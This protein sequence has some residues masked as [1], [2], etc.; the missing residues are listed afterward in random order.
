M[1][2][3][4]DLDGTLLD[5]PMG[6][7]HVVNMT[8]EQLG[9]AAPSDTTIRAMIGKPLQEMF[10]SFGWPA[11]TSE[12]SLTIFRSLFSE[13]VVS[14][15][16][17]LVF[18]GMRRSLEALMSEHR[19]AVATSKVLQSAEEILTAAGLREYFEVVLG[20]DSVPK[21]K[22]APDM[23]LLV[24]SCLGVSPD[25]CTVIGDSVH[26]MKMAISGG[27]TG[28]GVTWGVDTRHALSVAGASLIW[29]EPT[30]IPSSLLS[31]PLQH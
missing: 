24:A 19:L 13:H 20:A 6:I 9:L 2:I 25:S 7:V 31:Q 5:T 16:P 18:P 12:Q 8:A 22:P 29:D 21:P 4:F 17:S 10:I 23:A 28:V 11:S 3:I 30:K 1:A 26:D 14:M 15:A 27:M